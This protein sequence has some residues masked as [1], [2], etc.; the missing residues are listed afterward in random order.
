MS[1]A[2]L[3]IYGLVILSALAAVPAQAASTRAEYVAQ[4]DPICRAADRPTFKAYGLLFKAG[5]KIQGLDNRKRVMRIRAQALA[6]FYIRLSNIYAKTTTQIAAVASAPGD[7][8]T[9]TAWLAERSLVPD[10]GIRAGRAMNHQKVKR[11]RRLSNQAIS[12]SERAASVVGEFGFHACRQA[13]GDAGT[14]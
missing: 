8:Q 14:H 11:S 5:K 9:V 6:R 4:V 2:V 3:A 13:W 12:S 1:K 10:L 7:E